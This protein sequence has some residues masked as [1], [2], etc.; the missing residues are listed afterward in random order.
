[1]Y[2]IPTEILYQIYNKL[3]I[4]DLN[5][6][7]L[8]C[9]QWNQLINDIYIW[10]PKCYKKLKKTYWIDETIL[11]L[12]KLCGINNIQLFLENKQS[13]NQLSI[14]QLH[15]KSGYYM[16]KL[17]N[18][19]KLLSNNNNNIKKYQINKN[20]I[21]Y[22]KCIMIG[23]G[24]DSSNINRLLINY[25]L[26]W[27]ILNE[28]PDD[29]IIPNINLGIISELIGINIMIKLP[30]L[31]N[32]ILNTLIKMTCIIPKNGELLEDKNRISGKYL[33]YNEKNDN[34]NN[35]I[36]QIN[37]LPEIN[38]LLKECHVIL[39]II[40]ITKSIINELNWEQIIKEI[41][42]ILNNLNVNQ[43]LL[44]IGAGNE[45]DKEECI[46]L[47]D[48]VNKLQCILFKNFTF[49]SLEEQLILKIPNAQWRIWLTSS[50]GLDYDN[51]ANMINWGLYRNNDNDNIK[52]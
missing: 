39:Y 31:N 21:D 48:L 19:L 50:N 23:P 20:I 24:M 5:N 30:N 37:F 18:Y 1:M 52:V 33:L 28:I 32:Y 43:T 36:D 2:S 45:Y 47:I 16:R 51:L 17:Y 27:S 42:L 29:F 22:Y 26:N 46:S 35:N 13:I 25:I 40:D 14:N 7:S 34:N 12:L 8:V 9:K 6:C 38:I 44:I 41:I 11:I 10:L 15:F 4:N 3:N 49:D